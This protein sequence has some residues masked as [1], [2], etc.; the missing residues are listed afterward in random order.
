M[1]INYV[2]RIAMLEKC[3]VDLYSVIIMVCLLVEYDF[4]ICLLLKKNIDN[5]SIFNTK[6][7]N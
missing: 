7:Q 1:E 3:N 4:A 6:G 2:N 5:F